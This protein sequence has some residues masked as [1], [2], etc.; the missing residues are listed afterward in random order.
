MSDDNAS[1][2]R[3]PTAGLTR[4]LPRRETPVIVTWARLWSDTKILV[5]IQASVHVSVHRLTVIAAE[6]TRAHAVVS[7]LATQS[8]PEAMVVDLVLLCVVHLHDDI[9]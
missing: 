4:S 7:K 8:N 3:L 5:K 9:D 1:L 2:C 6:R